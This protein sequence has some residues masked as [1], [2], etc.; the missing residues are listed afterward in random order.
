M[1]QLA[2]LFLSLKDGSGP[3]SKE[4]SQRHSVLIL[5]LTLCEDKKSAALLLSVKKL[6]K[7]LTRLRKDDEASFPLRL[8]ANEILGRDTRREKEWQVRF[9]PGLHSMHAAKG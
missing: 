5:L 9:W 7:A 4:D 6:E 3:S 2:K 8:C 1:E